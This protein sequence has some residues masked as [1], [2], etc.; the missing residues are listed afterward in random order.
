MEK[1]ALSPRETDK[2]FKKQD[3]REPGIFMEV[4]SDNLKISLFGSIIR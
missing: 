2:A 3:N 1:N 4:L